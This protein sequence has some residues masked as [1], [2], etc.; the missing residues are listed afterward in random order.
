MTRTAGALVI[1]NEILTGKIEERNV[2]YLG[3]MLFELGIS[4]RR[5]VVCVDEVEVIAAELDALRKEH[6]WVFTSGGV[7][8]THDDVTLDG[9]AR[10]FGRKLVR[11]PELVGLIEGWHRKQGREV[12][13]A[14]LRMADVVEGAR[15]LRTRDMR[16]PVQIVENVVVLPGVPE[17][18]RMKLDAVRDE[19]D[20][21][22]GFVGRAVY[23]GCDEGDIAELLQRITERFAGVTVGSYP[24]WGGKGFRTKVTFDGREAASVAGAEAMLLEA[25]DADLVVRRE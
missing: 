10:S 20:E 25:L 6:D 16:W 13:E 14:H 9:V 15:Q 5:V 4:L 21:G 1:G 22:E 2:A 24:N 7:G 12:N 23:T 8:P 17:V 11:S 19:L 3:R 18:F